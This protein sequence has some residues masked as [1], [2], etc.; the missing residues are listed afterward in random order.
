MIE[1]NYVVT[2]YSESTMN[3]KKT[4]SRQRI[5]KSRQTQHEVEVKYVATKMTT[6]TTEVEKKDT[7]T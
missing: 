3:D 1:E 5:F 7:E 6:V 4:L 2:Q